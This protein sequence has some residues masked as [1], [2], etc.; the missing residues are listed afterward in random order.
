MPIIAMPPTTPPT[1]APVLELPSPD[2][3]EVLVGRDEDEDER[4][5]VGGT[6]V[7]EAGRPVRGKE[8]VF[9]ELVVGLVVELEVEVP[10]DA[11]GPISG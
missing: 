7:A 2:C 11:P 5:L 6:E 8:V 1:I 9:I 4:V 3:D 10:I